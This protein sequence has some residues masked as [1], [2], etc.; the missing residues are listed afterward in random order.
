MDQGIGDVH[1]YM[2]LPFSFVTKRELYMLRGDIQKN[3]KLALAYA[4][5]IKL[6]L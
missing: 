2:N 5:S 1:K 6:E 4:L 3:R